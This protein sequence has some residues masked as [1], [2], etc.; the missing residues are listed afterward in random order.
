[1]G[2]EST[3]KIVGI[4]CFVATFL[5]GVV[6]GYVSPALNGAGVCRSAP[7]G[8]AVSELYEYKPVPCRCRCEQLEWSDDNGKTWHE[9]TPIPEN[10]IKELSPDC[11]CS[12]CCCEPCVCARRAVPAGCPGCG[13]TPCC[14]CKPACECPAWPKPKEK[15]RCPY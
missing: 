4:Y 10:E 8:A 7:N 12:P 15:G 6:I 5:L 14:Q 1:M 3:V 13:C 2:R 11:H 9:A